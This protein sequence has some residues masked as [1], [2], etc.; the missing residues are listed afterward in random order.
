MLAQLRGAKKLRERN[1][2]FF[3]VDTVSSLTEV[4]IGLQ[5]NDFPKILVGSHGSI[6]E[7]LLRQIFL[8]NYSKICSAVMQSISRGKLLSITLPSA[9]RKHLADNGVPCSAFYSRVLLFLSALR[10]IAVGFVKSLILLS[11]VKK[12]SNPDCPYAVFVNL[13]QEYLPA[14]GDEKSYNLISWYKKSTIRKPG[15]EK[16][17][18]QAKVEKDY[19]APDD[20]IVTPSIF[21]KLGSFS[22]YIRFI[23]RNIC[24]LFVAVFGVLRGKW[25][26]GYLYH[27]NIFFNYFFYLNTDQFADCAFLSM[28]GG[29]D[30][31]DDRNMIFGQFQDNNFNIFKEARGLLTLGSFHA[32]I[33]DAI[34]V[35]SDSGKT[36][37][38][39]AYGKVSDTLYS[40]LRRLVTKD[41][42]GWR[43]NRKRFAPSPH[44]MSKL[45]VDAYQRSKVLNSVPS[46]T[47]VFRL[48]RP[49]PATYSGSHW[50]ACDARLSSR[51]CSSGE[52]RN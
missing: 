14:P 9:W 26:Y 28:D 41:V 39:A 4:P 37:G 44:N 20:L 24:A 40:E 6:A 33:S 11:P 29:G 36:S 16:I 1:E 22:G 10:Q 30:P 42:V 46:D 25:W 48:T 18:V 31:G 19:K 35:L 12:P 34:G 7:I 23:C 52:G 8:K 21:P 38:L 17:W 2:P 32:Y 3:V 43:F 13:L 51:N 27:E 49:L 15:I 5:E 47:N 50:R 45:K